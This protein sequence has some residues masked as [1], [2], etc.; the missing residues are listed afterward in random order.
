M[1]RDFEISQVSSKAGSRKQ[2]PGL[3]EQVRNSTMSALH[4]LLGD[5]FAS[6]DDMFFDLS[7]RASSNSE[8]NLY[9]ESMREVRIKKN[10]V[11]DQYGHAFHQLFDDMASGHLRP[12]SDPE[13]DQDSLALVEDDTVEQNVA[14]ASMISKAQVDYQEA[15]Y[16]LNCRFDVLLPS[17]EVGERNNPL[18]PHQ[19][20]EAFREVTRILDLDIRARIILYKQFDRLVVSKLGAIFAAANQ[21]LINAGVLPTIKSS[22]K[23]SPDSQ[24]AQPEQTAQTSTDSDP[25]QADQVATYGFREFS[26]LLTS[27]RNMNVRPSYFIPSYSSNPGPV[28]PQDELV[29]LL[30]ELQASLEYEQILKQQGVDI[31]SAIGEIMAGKDSGAE[32]EHALE[33]PDEDVINLVAMFF[34][35]ALSDP[36]LPV[37]FQALISRMQLPVLRMA[38]KDKAFFNSNKHPA[39]QLI[40]EIARLGVGWQEGEAQEQDRLYQVVEDIV[41]QLHSNA[42]ADATFFSDMLQ[43]LNV[44]ASRE[45]EKAQV[46]EKRSSETATG[47]AKTQAARAR[48]QSELYERLKIAEL[49]DPITR[50]LVHDWQ[51][52]LFITWL[53][54]GEESEAW[55]EALQLV[56]DLIWSVQYHQD[57]KSKAR[58]ARLLPTLRERIK[59]G[60]EKTIANEA[61]LDA[62]TK[63]VDNIHELLLRGRVEE[64][65][66]KELQPEHEIALSQAENT[67]SWKDM[68]AVE[69]Q[70]IQYQRITYDYIRKADSLPI[71]T[72]MSFENPRDGKVTR[73]KLAAKLE[74]TDS[75]VFV[76]RLG[77][78]VLEKTRKDVAYDMQQ[79]RTTILDSRPLFDRALGKMADSLRT[80]AQPGTN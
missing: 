51:N 4:A 68:T 73:A 43:S 47:Q 25:I 63:N 64:I 21:I 40:N 78:K 42:D 67:K 36:N 61:E 2:L 12:H 70:Q 46:V 52:V 10:G 1:G 20:C 16:H 56:D 53:K 15:L 66:Y 32:R 45:E 3:V 29:L 23:K 6:C 26:N 28:V 27:L 59:R 79:S 35:F 71:G 57:E 72:W 31:R 19:I 77:L 44:Y 58:R 17:I 7:S 34:D 38:L 62:I 65:G 33:S 76:N 14:L 30:A 5:M 8:Q 60:L 50:F 22:V 39:R 18:D 13:Q 55:L 24:P 41:H 74:A 9:F 49:P 54:Q 37:P 69:R 48:I 75:Y 80:I 11:Q